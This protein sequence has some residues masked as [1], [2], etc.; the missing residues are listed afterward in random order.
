ML[1]KCSDEKLSADIE[2]VH[3]YQLGTRILAFSVMAMISFNFFHYLDGHPQ[4][5][6]NSLVPGGDEQ[7]D[8]PPC[9]ARNAHCA[10]NLRTIVGAIAVLTMCSL[11]QVRVKTTLRSTEWWDKS[12]TI[13]SESHAGDG[14]EFVVSIRVKGH[15]LN[16][17]RIV[18]D[19]QTRFDSVRPHQRW[20]KV[21]HF[22]VGHVSAV[23]PHTTH[24][25]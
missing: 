23:P 20:Q 24:L 15:L 13:S 10:C 3:W 6:Q 19:Q 11:K 17:P 4:P 12:R 8:L 25:A 1:R 14:D 5:L 16:I 21:V 22:T 9:L 18:Q 2:I 7:T